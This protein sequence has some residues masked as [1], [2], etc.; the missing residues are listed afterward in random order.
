[1]T[2]SNIMAKNYNREIKIVK[3]WIKKKLKNKADEKIIR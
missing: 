1:M 2:Y 3:N